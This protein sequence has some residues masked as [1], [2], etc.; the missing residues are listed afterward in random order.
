[1]HDSVFNDEGFD[2]SLDDLKF[3]M[4][5][6]PF[7]CILQIAVQTGE[8]SYLKQLYS[9]LLEGLDP[10]FQLVTINENDG[11]GF[12]KAADEDDVLRD[13]S[14]LY[15]PALSIVLF[16]SEDFGRLSAKTLQKNFNFSPWEF[17]HRVELPKHAKPRVTA[18][19][20]FY[21]TFPNLPLW[22][23]C[24]VHYGN[25]H[26]RF[27]IFVKDFMAMRLFYE[28]VTGKK[29]T[30]GSSGFCF[31]TMYSQS[32]F[33]LQLSLKYMPQ[34]LPH[35][36]NSVH[37]KFKVKDINAIMDAFSETPVRKGDELWVVKDPDGNSILIEETVATS[38]TRTKGQLSSNISLETS[39]Y[40]TA[41]I[42]TESLAGSINISPQGNVNST[43]ST[44]SSFLS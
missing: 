12:P 2:E 6:D 16:L 32:G 34:I 22:S 25:E 39:D 1:M 9:P 30:S 27:H 23:I 24:P 5:P 29:A 8:S 38:L 3:R 44:L 37:L 11:F 43:F 14:I 26:L 10:T 13:S 40:E 15:C 31:F 41:S 28:I 21:A 42:D 36:S 35:P 18:G 33:D 7:G 4:A 20:D 19:Q 17:H